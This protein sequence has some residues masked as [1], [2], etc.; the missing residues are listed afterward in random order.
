MEEEKRYKIKL[1]SRTEVTVLEHQLFKERWI[2]YFGS[3]D[4]ILEFIKN[5]EN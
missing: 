4:N 1:D 5:Y 2:K 3:I